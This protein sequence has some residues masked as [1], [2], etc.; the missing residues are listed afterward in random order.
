VLLKVLAAA[1]FL[2]CLDQFTKLLVVRHLAAGQSV[3]VGSW[4]RIRRL[5]NVR[6][7]L[8][9]HQPRVLLLAWGLLLAGCWVLIWQ[10][11]FFQSVAA[12]VAL[13]LA[14]GGAGSNLYDQL[15][16]G[17]VLDFI[18]L[19]WWPVFNLADVA[20]TLGVILILWSLL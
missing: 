13:G 19:G 5:T 1:G 14:L 9:A 11:H 8:L 17:A 3:A 10:G 4:F 16:C 2:F 20:I 7:V 15:R 18:D 12:Q 6:G